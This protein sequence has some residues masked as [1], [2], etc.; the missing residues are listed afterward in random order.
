[1]MVIRQEHHIEKAN[2]FLTLQISMV[3][4]IYKYLLFSNVRQE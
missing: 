1:M 2:H 4:G 3:S